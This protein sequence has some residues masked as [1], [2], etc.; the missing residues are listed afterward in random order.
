MF[1]FVCVCMCAWCTYYVQCS[2]LFRVWSIQTG[3]LLNTLIHHCEAVLHLRFADGLMV[4]CSK[5][6]LTVCIIFK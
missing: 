5:V 6:C 4:T 2:P 3:E 1:R